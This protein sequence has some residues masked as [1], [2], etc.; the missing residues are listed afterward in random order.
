MLLLD[1]RVKV[2]Q[3]TK[4]RARPSKLPA[5]IEKALRLLYNP[6]PPRPIPVVD[7]SELKHIL[8]TF[9][10]TPRS[11]LN[12]EESL[13]DLK[14]IS[15]E[16]S[17]SVRLKPNPTTGQTLSDLLSW[18]EIESVLRQFD[19]RTIFIIAAWCGR[20]I[21]SL[22]DIEHSLKRVEQENGHIYWQHDPNAFSD[23]EHQCRTEKIASFGLTYELVEK[24]NG[25]KRRQMAEVHISA[26][27]EEL[28]QSLRPFLI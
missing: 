26:A 6:I 15:R 17:R 28:K 4:R 2:S 14:Q 12:T 27:L 16:A 5:A 1:Y 7:E 21:W 8:T 24:K 3:V 19:E 20:P 11:I 10:N 9:F 25:K 23:E 18:A 13:G 22:D